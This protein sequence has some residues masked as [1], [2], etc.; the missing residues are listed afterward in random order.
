MS[1]EI[2]D[3]GCGPEIAGTRI[4]VYDIWEY[5]RVGRHHTYIAVLLGL[6]SA[7]VL[8]ALDYIEQHKAEVLADYQK[9]LD[10]IAKGPPPEV[11]AKVDAI[12]AKYATLWEE[13]RKKAL[14]NGDALIHGG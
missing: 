2:I 11:Q 13:R 3:R 5:A 9:I 1:T 6:S 7:Q 4:T 12:R 8:T 14:E 10:R